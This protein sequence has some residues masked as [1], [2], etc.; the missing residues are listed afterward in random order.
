MTNL[1]PL[2]HPLISLMSSQV[3]IEA[4]GGKGA[5]LVKLANAGLPVPNGFLIPTAAYRQFVAQNQLLPQIKER[6]AGLDFASPNSLETASEA[7]RGWFANGS[8][9][10][11]LISALETGWQWL[12]A[13][14]VAVRSSA[15]AEDLP[16]LSFAG[17]QDTFLNIIGIQALQKAVVDCWSS[18]WTARAIG[19]RARNN[20][21]HEDVA[22]CVVVQNMV[23]S[24]ASG[25]LFTANPLS[26]RRAETV[27]DATLGLGEALVSGMVEPDHYV[28]DTLQNV[29]TQKF[30]GSKSIQ[31]RSKSEG[32]VSAQSAVSSNHQA[33]SDPVILQLA[34]IGAKIE[35]LYHFPQ[36][37]EWAVEQGNIYILQARP[38]TSLYPLPDNLPPEPL[39]AL[40]GLHVIQGVMEPFTPLGQT[41]IMEVLV[42]GG[43]ALGLH[44]TLEEQ[45]AFYVAGERVW[46]NITPIVRHPRGHEA[47]PTV[48][49]NLDPGV[50]QA[51]EEILRD[52]RLAPQPGSLSLLKPWNILRFVLP[53]LFRVM[54]FMRAPE[55]MAHQTL[56]AFDNRVAETAD[57]GQSTGNLGVDF[58]KRVSLLLEARDLFPDFVIPNGVTAV[59]AGMIPFF[60]VLKRF[61]DQ[62]V[63]PT[64][65][66]Q[67]ETLYLEI[68]RGLP[69][70]VTTQMDLSLWQTAQTLQADA[71]S[72]QL[73]ESTNAAALAGQYLAGNLPPAAQTALSEFLGRYGMRGLGE[74]DIGRPRWVENPEHIIGV[75]Q[76]YLQ[77]KDPDLAPDAVFAHGAQEAKIAAQKLE[78]AVRQLPMGRIK[79]HLVR[80]AVRRY[81]ALAGL[82]EAPKFFAIRM[83]GIMRQGLLASGEQMVAAGLFEQADDLFFLHVAEL[84]DLANQL[85]NW[86]V[87]DNP[88]ASLVA[89]RLTI[90]ERRALREREMR[91]AQIPRVLLSDGTAYYEGLGAV[92][93]KEGQFFGDPVSP[94]VVEGAV[95][96][97]FNPLDAKLQPGEILVCPGTDPAWTPLFLTASGLVMET[98]GMMTHGSVVAREYGIPAVVGVHQATSRLHTGDRIRVDGRSGLIE[99]M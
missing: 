64:A 11:S 30:L 91:R 26:G 37:I 46:I 72:A 71:A 5:N 65:D 35:S 54:R 89:L 21:A 60:G 34:G 41:A 78:T 2:P 69:N 23:Q 16:D 50:A 96:V 8:I 61:S 95:R 75:L 4:V 20:I 63:V 15:T 28:V 74:I 3:S 9:S 83:M 55:A 68:A 90:K 57:R 51:F 81:R 31:I 73:F 88:P 17:Q 99:V 10:P 67:F 82:R 66:P 47:Y 33:I 43:H 38:I 76:S 13:N 59:V 48:F 77:I 85:A 93:A 44:L 24:E 97:V 45:T 42:G 19:Y 18:L 1:E 86:K 22:L 84:K 25:V 80:F 6:L 39:K 40:V 49:K 94:G 87:G 52:P 32:G 12:G 53:N 92:E 58:A 36:D 29:I 56:E 7:I 27:I 62:L 70:N 79:A 14:P 98:G